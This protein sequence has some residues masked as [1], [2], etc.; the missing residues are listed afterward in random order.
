M[1]N[2]MAELLPQLITAIGILAFAVSV[3][4]Q[5]IK[6][7][8]VLNKVPTDIVV[9]ILSLVF[10]IL[11]FFAYAQYASVALTWYLIVGAFIGGFFVA[12]ITMYGWGKL[13][14]LWSRFNPKDKK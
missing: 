4:T 3:V 12:F 8:G 5:V 10:T 2:G 11:A 1:I 9:I 7:L 6:G 13:T 14:E